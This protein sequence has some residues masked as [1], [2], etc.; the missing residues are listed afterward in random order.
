MTPEAHKLF[1]WGTQKRRLYDRLICGPATASEIVKDLHIY[2]YQK[3]IG[4]VRRGLVGTG[5][6]VKATP[7]NG[8]K[9][10]WEYRLGLVSQGSDNTSARSGVTATAICGDEA[11][12]AGEG[13]Q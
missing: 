9:N 6:T 11:A 5:V 12:S 7:I 2:Q 1:R 10:L 13:R 3:K 8:K 4:E